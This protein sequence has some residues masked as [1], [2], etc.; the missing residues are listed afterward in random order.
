[1][2]EALDAVEHPVAVV[3]KVII[4]TCAYAGSGSVLMI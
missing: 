4:E 1:M 3:A 2:L